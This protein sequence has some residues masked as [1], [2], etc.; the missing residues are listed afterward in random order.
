MKTAKRLYLYTVSG[1]GLSL[2]IWGVISLLRLLLSKVGVGADS[3]SSLG[4]STLY[5]ISIPS[6]G[7]DADLDT[8]AMAVAIG[9]VGLALW[10]F[11]WLIVERMV[12]GQDEAAAGERASIIRS[13]YFALLLGGT[14]YTAASLALLQATKSIGDLLN[15]SPSYSLGLGDA[16]SLAV[17]VVLLAVWGYHAWVR[18]RDVKQGAI[19]GA[20]AWVSRT[21]LYGAVFVGLVGALGSIAAIITTILYQLANGDQSYSF[22]PDE[23]GNSY[24]AWW[25]RPI[26]GALLGIA[27]WGAIWLAHWI[28]S[29]RLRAGETT[30]AGAER[31]SKTRLG[32]LMAVVLWGAASVVTGVAS[33]VGQ[34]LAWVLTPDFVSDPKW[35]PMLA[36]ALGVIPAA[37]A[38]WWHQKRAM[39][40]APNAPAGISARRIAGYLIALVGLTAL[41][42]GAV[43]AL[44]AIFNE[45]WAASPSYGFDS[46]R[47]DD[48]W[49]YSVAIGVGALVTGLAVWVLSWLS[50]QRRSVAEGAVE[51]G[52]SS[53]SYY[54]YLVLGASILI[55]AFSLST[56]IYRYLRLGLGLDE[57][58]LGLE[59]SGSIAMLLVAGAILAYH[60][61][62][63]R[64]DMAPPSVAAP[65]ST[66]APAAPAKPAKAG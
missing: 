27:I 47:S 21:Y 5:G 3:V 50:A 46:F 49:K 51:T 22:Y 32:F 53:R 36:P 56:I 41:A 20:A 13:V 30:Q 33:G 37:V 29:N 38:W 59:V 65:A 24:A 2:L 16:W 44:S 48:W 14:L 61:L 4:I 9:G 52:S 45:W 42:G 35:Y 63:L 26:V 6:I 58:Y 64:R 11:H 66:P 28:Y 39:A 43:Q 54:L 18:N 40:E 31:S 57:K 23:P 7:G 1:V 8:I 10:L 15:A 12:R 19:A 62:V 60:A 34:V 17:I 25:V 55:G